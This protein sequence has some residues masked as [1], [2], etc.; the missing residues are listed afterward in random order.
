MRKTKGLYKRGNVYWMCY[1]INGKLYRESTGKTSQKEAEYVQACRRK[2]IADEKLPDIKRANFKLAELAKEYLKWAERQRSYKDKKLWIK[3]LI[4]VFGSLDLKELNTMAIEQWQCERLKRNKPATVNRILATLKHMIS[5]GVQW[6][7][8]SENALKQVRNVKLLEENNR[9]LRFLNVD[10]CQ[11]LISCCAK[12]LRPIVIIALNTGMRKSEILSLRWEQV[13]L[14]HGFILLSTTKNGERR[15]IPINTTVE[16]VLNEIPHSVESVHVF[17]NR[18]GSPYRDMKKSFH[19]AIRSAG[20]HDFKFHDLRHT[21]ASHLV[22]AG[23]D[24]TSVKELMGHK[25]LTMTMRYSHLSPTH[26][27][28]AVNTLDQVLNNGGEVKVSSQFGSQS[29]EITPTASHKSLGNK[30]RPVG[31]E[32]TTH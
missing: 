29:E 13:D 30:V 9:R 8:A 14:R 19:T 12:H 22:M 4:E 16:D 27:R 11:T 17:T 28:K 21:F 20:I 24:L 7:M 6:E 5:K 3:Q 23:I 25:S 18:N 15:E 26:K 10:E 32:P 2:E 31:V 1:K